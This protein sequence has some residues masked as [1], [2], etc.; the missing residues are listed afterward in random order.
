M[1]TSHGSQKYSRKICIRCGKTKP[2]ADFNRF[3]YSYDGLCPRCK[4]CDSIRM[5]VSYRDNRSARLK[6]A[7]AYR[8][9]N[10]PAIN[11]E[12]RKHYKIYRTTIR[13]RAK[14]RYAKHRVQI[15][16]ECRKWRTET[17]RGQYLTCRT[18]ARNRKLAF[19]ISY[20]QFSS[21]K[22]KPCNYC[23]VPLA[24]C[25]MD[26]V[27]NSEGYINGNV[28]PACWDCNR[29]KH[30][31]TK[32]HFLAHC[33]RIVLNNKKYYEKNRKKYIPAGGRGGEKA[34]LPAGRAA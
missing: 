12:K 24:R 26:R 34:W 23:G 32:E 4:K 11:A 3:R 15:L 27:K 14:L 25:S 21:T 8:K 20:E 28:V 22:G 10:R 13:A 2:L 18:G 6:K 31:M 9:K 1:K 17:S 33:K 16:E 5:Q 19:T 7:A 29:M 30:A